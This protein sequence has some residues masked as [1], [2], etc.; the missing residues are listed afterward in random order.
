[1]G[2]CPGPEGV[3]L[4]GCSSPGCSKRGAAPR[5]ALLLP[6]AAWDV[7]PRD[8]SRSG[9]APRWGGVLRV[10]GCA[11]AGGAPGLG[12][13]WPGMRRA[14]LAACR[15]AAPAPGSPAGDRGVPGAQL[16]NRA[17]APA[18]STA[19]ASATTALPGGSRLGRGPVGGGPAT[20]GAWRWCA[21]LLLRTLQAAPCRK[22]AGEA[23]DLRQADGRHLP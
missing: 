12:A 5:G 11:Q 21:V 19:A 9:G 15:G 1:M 13:L 3:P 10:R 6:R 23:R 7:P 14:L 16:G 4:R 18:P 2:R 20:C 22:G 17:G 8:C